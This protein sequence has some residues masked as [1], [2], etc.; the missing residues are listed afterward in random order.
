M[1][2]QPAR[3]D[4]LR[5]SI[6]AIALAALAESRAA[7]LT[8]LEELAP[9]EAGQYS[10]L[11]GL[12]YLN[13]G[14]IG[15]TP[16]AVR[17]ALE[18]Y[19][20]ICEEFPSLYIWGEPWEAAR[21]EV[22]AKLALFLNCSAGDLAITRNT[23]EGFN[24]LAHGLPLGP[25]DEVLFSSLN[26]D[27][28][29][30]CFEHT[31]VTR[32]FT[33]RQFDIPLE[34]TTNRTPEQIIALHSDQ[35]RLGTKLLVLPHIDNLVG[36]RHPVAAIAREAR[37]AG[38]EFI[39]VDGAQSMGMIP[40]D[41][42]ALDIDFYFVSL[43]KWLQAPK[44]VGSFYVRPAVRSMVRPALVT[45]GQS[46]WAG[47]SR[48]FEDFGT[49]DLPNVLAVADAITFH[50]RIGWDERLSRLTRLHQT[51]RDMARRAGL[52][53]LSPESWDHGGSLYTIRLPGA[54]ATDIERALD[55]HSI[56]ARVF[57]SPDGARLRLSPNLM[58]TEDELARCFRAIA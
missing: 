50:A 19:L 18:N 11:P 42:A 1:I 40:I 22:R 47:S 45:W 14:A 48:I 7:A 33:V 31:A 12:A 32:G 43:H 53:W 21:E 36:I 20:R 15:T 51:A 8:E 37:R 6:G 27:G 30:R 34:N 39:A 49:R 25:G 10:L 57:A 13:H 29:A 5:H 46:R 54:D 3:R 23:T 9:D 4:F 52:P 24:V 2:D 35:I 38:V 55:E 16:I 44:V 26:H 56:A 41:L 28:A 58:N 17:R